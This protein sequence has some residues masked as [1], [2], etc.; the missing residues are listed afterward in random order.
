M[1]GR[2]KGAVKSALMQKKTEEYYA[3]LDAQFISYHEWICAREQGSVKADICKKVS[4]PKAW[5]DVTRIEAEFYAV[6]GMNVQVIDYADCTVEFHDIYFKYALEMAA[7][8]KENDIIVFVNGK[9][10]LSEHALQIISSYFMDNPA[11]VLAYGDEDEWNSN[12]TLRMNPWFKPDFSPDTLLQHFYFGNVI[13]LRRSALETIMWRH[14]Q[15]YLMNLYDMCMQ[16]AFPVNK[17]RIGHIQ[18][19]LYHAYNLQLLCCGKEYDG[20][21]NLYTDIAA[22]RNRRTELAGYNTDAEKSQKDKI[23]IVIPSKDHPEVLDLCLKTLMNTKGNEEIEIIIVDNGS[24]EEAR[25]E[26]EKMKVK[27]GFNYIFRP[28]E[29]NFS[30][31]CNLGAKAACGEYI[32]FLNDDIEAIEEGWLS[33]MRAH[34]AKSHVGAVGAKLYY[35]ES[36]TIQHAGVTNL[37]L[38]P[39][40]KLQFLEDNRSYYD[41]RNIFD[42]NI[43]AV[44]AACLMVRKTVFEEC[45]GFSEDLAVAFNDVELC[46][47][48]YKAGYYNVQCNQAVLYHHESLSRGNDESEE[49]QVRLQ[50]ERNKMYIMHPDLYGVDPFYHPYMNRQ[51]LDTNFSFAYEY[52]AGEE[53]DVA[54][55][56]LLKGGLKQEWYNECLLISLEYA[57]ELSAWTE[58]PD[59]MG[60]ALY[61]QGYQF[62]IGSDNAGFKRSI[63]LKNVES[64]EIFEIPCGTVFRPDLAQ[65]V[66]EGNA[67]LCG[68]ACAVEKEKLPAGRY[69]AGCMAVSRVDRLKLCRFVNKFIEI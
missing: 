7:M 57:G 23:S 37:L 15:D 9:E 40:H 66:K 46:F 31:M 44:T 4:V 3:L 24:G 49:K 5:T 55:P 2:L 19:I 12:R 54:E 10:H 59:K 34:A 50:K 56:A 47:R 26:Y 36:K 28:M 33:K 8:Q 65:N 41:G 13:A 38:G 20:L 64:G 16:L 42:R 6:N 18:Y 61:F 11:R 58:G 30:K 32:L 51:L 62:V 68:F 69:Q 67:S 21:K 52:P 1:I 35:P 39:V 27:Y 63:L 22:S 14:S 43:L 17:D 53:L 25:L 60:D 48:I 45:G 29:F